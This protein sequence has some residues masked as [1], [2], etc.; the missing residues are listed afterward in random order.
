MIILIPALDFALLVKQENQKATSV[1]LNV[2][3][4]VKT[5]EFMESVSEDGY[6][7]KANSKAHNSK[8]IQKIY[9]TTSNGTRFMFAL[10]EIV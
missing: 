1:K 3:Q 7:Q 4:K 9:L 10:L 6:I 8:L 5:E 2:M